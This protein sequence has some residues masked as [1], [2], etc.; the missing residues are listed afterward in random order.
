MYFKMQLTPLFS[1]RPSVAVAL[2]TRSNYV[3]RMYEYRV[4]EVYRMAVSFDHL[5]WPG[6]RFDTTESSHSRSQIH[7]TISHNSLPDKL[8]YTVTLSLFIGK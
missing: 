2:F 6:A 7:S 3:L 4:A 1:S 8:H 5:K